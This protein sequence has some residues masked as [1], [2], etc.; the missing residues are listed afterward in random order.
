MPDGI[1]ALEKLKY[2]DV[3]NNF[4]QGDVPTPKAQ[5]SRGDSGGGGKKSRS[6]TRHGTMTLEAAGDE[7]RSTVRMRISTPRLSKSRGNSRDGLSS[8]PNSP[9]GNFETRPTSPGSR[10]MKRTPSTKDD[11]IVMRQVYK[12]E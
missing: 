8:E 5:L 11:D 10:Q 9:M 7:R 4:I 12:E 1:L 3:G 6:D 2:F